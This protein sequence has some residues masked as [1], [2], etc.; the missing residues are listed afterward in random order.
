MQEIIKNLYQSKIDNPF[1]N[2]V[3]T[4]AYLLRRKAG[5]ILFYSSKFIEEHF[6]L[7]NGCGGVVHQIVNHR[8]E[9]SNFC[10]S[11]LNRF[12]A[13]LICHKEEEESISKKCNVGRT[14]T[15]GHILEDIE[16][17]HTPGHL[18]RKYMFL[19]A[20]KRGKHSFY[21]RYIV[22]S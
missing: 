14:I 2:S 10:D 11:V 18:S 7:I 9:A 19:M 8:D 6:E 22:S 17:I 3:Q 12:A 16:A 5:N 21:Q 15:E 1:G 20:G 13:P 4:A